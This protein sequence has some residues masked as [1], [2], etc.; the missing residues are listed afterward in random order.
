MAHDQ[1]DQDGQGKREHAQ[2]TADDGSGNHP[3]MSP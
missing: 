3:G 2:A 1:R